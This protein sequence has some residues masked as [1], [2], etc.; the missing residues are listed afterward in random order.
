MINSKI[1]LNKNIKAT[2]RQG[3]DTQDSLKLFL[4]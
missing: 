4:A 2:V 3:T 1:N